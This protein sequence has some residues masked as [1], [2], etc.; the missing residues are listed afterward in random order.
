MTQKLGFKLPDEVRDTMQ[1]GRT[2]RL[3]PTCDADGKVLF[4]D[5]IDAATENVVVTV[6]AEDIKVK[7]EPQKS[8]EASGAS[9]RG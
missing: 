9:V 1:I 2:Y 6:A 4:V 7:G 8:I 5:V 3:E